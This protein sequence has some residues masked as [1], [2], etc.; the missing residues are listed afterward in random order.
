MRTRTP[1]MRDDRGQVIVLVSAALFTLLMV[2]G[3]VIDVGIILEKKRQLQ[4]AADAAALAAAS[5]AVDNPALAQAAAEQ[6]L[7]LNGFDP[8]DASLIIAVDP[9]YSATEVEVTVVAAIPTAFF[10]IAGIDSKTVTVRAVGEARP[11]RGAADYAFVALSETACVALEKSGNSDLTIIG[12]ALITNSSC[13]PDALWAHGS[14]SIV[15]EGTDF[16]AGGEARVS[17]SVYVTPEVTSVTDRIDDP[18]ASLTAPNPAT[19][20]DS[21]GTS[22]SPAMLRINSAQTLRPGTYWGG[23]EANAD[24]TLEPGIYV[25]AGGGIRT[26]GGGSLTGDGVMIYNTD[27]PGVETCGQVLLTGSNDVALTGMTSGQYANITFWQD[28]DCNLAFRFSGGHSGTA[29]V[30]YVPGARFDLTGGGVLGSIQVFADTIEIS[31][32]ADI[33]MNFNGYVGESG[34]PTMVLSE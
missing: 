9:N 12:G 3:M 27:N 25:I 6:Y 2:V 30:V 20:P 28:V 14:G 15:A 23:I 26:A 29:G 32:N 21:A 11:I 31:G 10:T 24:V 22:A 8:S 16:Y 1:D 17:G 33:T 19:S 34:I 13:T 18:L 7:L 5:A 4:N